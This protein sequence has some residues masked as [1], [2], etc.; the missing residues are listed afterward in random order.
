MLAVVLRPYHYLSASAIGAAG[1]VE[2]VQH[3]DVRVRKREIEDLRVLLDPPVV[4]RLCERWDR[5]FLDHLIAGRDEEIDRMTDADLDRDAGF[6][7]HEVRTWVAATA[8]ARA[9]GPVDLELVSYRLIPEW[10]TG[11]AII[12]GGAREAA[13]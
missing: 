6:G 9:L 3:G 11:M 4:G 13:P 1:L 2:R 8:A 7:G 12:A 10:I 5:A